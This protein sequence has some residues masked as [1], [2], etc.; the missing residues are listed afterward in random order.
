MSYFVASAIRELQEERLYHRYY[1]SSFFMHISTTTKDHKFEKLV[2]D[3]ILDAWRNDVMANNTL[4]I[5]QDFKDA[6]DDLAASNLA[7][8]QMGEISLFMPTEQ[9]VLT[10]F[11]DIM[12]QESYAVQIVN[13]STNRNLLGKDGQ[14]KLTNPLNIF[15]GGFKLDRGITI[16]HL[17]GFMYGR[18]PQTRQ[19]DTVLQHHRM[20]GNRSKEDMSV[21]RLHT[22]QNLYDTMQWIDN[23]DHQLREIFV[24]AI[25]NPSAPMP[26]IAIQ[27]DRQRGISPCNRNRLLISDLETFDSFKRFTPFGFQTDC[28]TNIRQIVDRIDTKLMNTPGYQQGKP[29]LIRKDDAYQI[30]RDIRSTYVYNRR[31]DNNAHL[32]WDENLMIAAIEKY[33]PADG[34][35][36]CYVVTGRN[37]SRVRK[38]GNFVDAPEDGNTDTPIARQYTQGA[39]A[40]PFLML[41][42][43]NGRQAQGWRDAEFYWPCLRLPQNIEP[44]VFCK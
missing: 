13:S 24:K 40:H 35:L 33:L 37:M 3:T 16:D 26:T 22:T 41:L 31:I 29:F 30:I 28:A 44:C 18:N 20:Y 11:K 23:M 21:T 12:T 32:Q 8:N 34:M 25:Q 14:L 42:R 36:W 19:S 2:V 17:L 5:M 43:E 7:G 38:N 6:Y 4:G 15:I 9:E 39:N 1:N 10:R 27:F